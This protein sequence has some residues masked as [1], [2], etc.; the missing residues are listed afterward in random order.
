MKKINLLACL[1]STAI[2]YAQ[3]KFEK[4]YFIDNLGN[5]KEVLIRNVDWKEN[6]VDFEYKSDI[7]SDTKKENINNVQEFS[8]DGSGKYIRATVML[9]LS[10][11]NLDLMS[12]KKAPNFKEKT[13]FLKYI[14]E[15]KATLLYYEEDNIRRF[16]YSSEKSN[17]QQL[18]YK[19]YYIND[20]SIAYNEDYKKQIAEYLKCGIENEQLRNINYTKKDL[21]N[22]FTQYNECSGAHVVDY[23]KLDVKKGL[24]HLS[25][26]PGINFSSLKSQ[27]V[28]EDVKADFGSQTSFRIGLEFEY[29]LP[30]NK[31]KWAFFVEPTYQYYKKNVESIG[32]EGYYYEYKYNATVDYKSIEIPIGVRHY[33]FL[34]DRSKI[35]VNA[36]YV[37]DINMKSSMKLLFSEIEIGSGSNFVIGAGYKYNN[38]FSAEFR[39]GTSRN[40]L[41]DYQNLDSDYKTASL[42]LGYTLF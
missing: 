12:D 30:F 1:L 16:F 37:A 27:Y 11:G 32:Y 20:D 4:G 29:V 22:I 23:G 31:N 26:R 25:I 7:S 8:I 24:F 6:P 35:F 10:S 18:I 15:G 5:K 9:D 19:P 34:N 2:Y 38:R 21:A 41:R 36:A 28:Y 40:L 33:F 13:I 17:P 39:V 3:I 42:I 14:I